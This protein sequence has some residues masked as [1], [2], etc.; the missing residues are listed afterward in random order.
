[1]RSTIT[2]QST[3]LVIPFVYEKGYDSIESLRCF[4]EK[5]IHKDKIYDH[6]GSLI[7]GESGKQH[8][9]KAFTLDQNHRVKFGLPKNKSHSIKYMG[10]DTKFFYS[11]IEAEIYTFSTQVGFLCI[12]FQVSDDPSHYDKQGFVPIT[13]ENYEK[14]VY[15]LR[16]FYYRNAI[17]EFSQKIGKDEY[18][19]VPFHIQDMINKMLESL[20]VQRYFEQN[21]TTPTQAQV[22]SIVVLNESNSL[23]ESFSEI[24]SSSEIGQSVS[25]QIAMLISDEKSRRNRLVEELA[26]RLSH[27]FKDTYL[28]PQDLK[29]ASRLPSLFQ[30]FENSIWGIATEGVANVILKTDQPETNRFFE[31]S[32]FSNVKGTYFYLYLLLL[33][34]KYGLL[35]LSIKAGDVYKK[36]K[37]LS[38][39]EQAKYIYQFREEI[40][41]FNVTSVYKHASYITHQSD[42]Y[43]LLHEMMGINELKEELTNE[44]EALTDHLTMVLDQWERKLEKIKNEKS[45]RTNYLIQFIT[46]ILLPFTIVTGFFGMNLPMI[47]NMKDWMFYGI[48][49]VIFFILSIIHSW[50]YFKEKNEMKN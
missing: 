50:A 23:N 17:H 24:A 10:K 48:L 43:H 5:K 11:I 46:Y 36:I 38:I 40:I 16:R 21:V 25:P 9:G 44:V 8:I 42:W 20:Q 3:T 45:Q 22:F 32:Y 2:K 27:S 47:K 4:Q 18:K 19:V 34:Q 7:G 28:L 35:Y 6:I 39:D 13:K 26:Y 14:A 49:I 31:Q 37:S 30:P 1:M 41:E 33:N 15:E 12:S 29:R